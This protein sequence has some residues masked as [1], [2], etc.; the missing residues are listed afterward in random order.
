M[1]KRWSKFMVLALSL[2]LLA[3]MVASVSAANG[4]NNS[5]AGLMRQ[6]MKAG[7]Q[8]AQTA[9]KAV[10]DLTGLST[11]DVQSQRVEGKSL[12]AIAEAKGVSEQNVI[13]KVIAERTATLEQLKADN[14]IT[15]A[16]YQSCLDNMQDRV[17]ANIERTTVGAGNGNQCG[18]GNGRMQ[19][20][21]QGQGMGR[22]CGQ[23]P[24]NCPNAATT[25]S[26]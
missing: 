21:G 7:Q 10:A 12:A 15:A 1:K 22:G 5:P 17:K 18:Q 3:G 16:Q 13:D 4:A 20:M 19:G 26:K 9:L 23:N 6:G 2:L 14:K 24:A 11:V 8:C 25:V